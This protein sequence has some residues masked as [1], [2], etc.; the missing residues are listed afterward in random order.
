MPGYGAGQVRTE[1]LAEYGWAMRPRRPH[2]PGD[3]CE[4]PYKACTHA[5][6]MWQPFA[7]PLTEESGPLDSCCAL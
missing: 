2:D 7:A 4:S 1:K 5:S 3:G 6:V